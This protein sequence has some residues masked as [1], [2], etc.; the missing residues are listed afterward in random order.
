[1]DNLN[2]SE[3]SQIIKDRINNLETTSQESNEGTIVFLSDGIARIHGLSEVMY[4]ELI[5]FEGGITGMALN[6]ERDSVGVVI[7][8]DY[9]K[10]AEGDT[11]KC[12][13]KILEVPVGTELLGRVVDALGN[14]IDGK[15]PVDCSSYSPIEKVA[16][17]V[18]TRKPVDQPVQI[19]L[20]AVDSMVPIGRGQ[21]EL[22][23]GDRQT[24]KTAIALDAIINQKG[25]G[26]KCIYVAVGQKQSS[27]AAVV[28][29]LEEFGA[30]DH[31]I[32][33]VSYTHLT[34]PTIAVG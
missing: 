10:L 12:T 25:T 15:G 17:G 34:L 23:I 1:M 33:A 9:K 13:G 14:P 2:P 29:K 8:G 31:T 26:V 22:I 7:F 19:G 11:A 28:R 30:M 4:G 27:I 20:K 5:E 24:G 6:L 16:P 18:M 21:R 3:I 32:V